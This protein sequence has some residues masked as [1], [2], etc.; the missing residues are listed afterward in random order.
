MRPVSARGLAGI[1][2]LALVPQSL[3]AQSTSP[4]GSGV[5]VETTER[6]YSLEQRTL[7]EVIARLNS[8]RLEG[9]SGP[10]AQGLTDYRI[11]P[12]W[13]PWAAGGRCRVAAL[14]LT[15]RIVITLPEWT[16]ASIAPSTERDRWERIETAIR[17]HE[18]THRDLTI[19]AAERLH[20][21]LSSLDVRGCT[22]LR[23]AFAGEMSV[24]DA[25]LTDAH[26]ELDRTAQRRLIGG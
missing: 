1:V 11:Q 22:A 14:T 18:Y 24:A 10:L 16:H 17:T 3:P 6:Y 21:R 5:R 12:E 26:A 9:E 7:S 20:G 2:L 13:R 4:T 8:T 23:Q 15:V 19:E 25:R